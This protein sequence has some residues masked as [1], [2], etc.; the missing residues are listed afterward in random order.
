MKM[1]KPAPDLVAGLALA[2]AILT[3]CLWL[4]VAMAPEPLTL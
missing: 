2:A 1:N 3:L 4:A